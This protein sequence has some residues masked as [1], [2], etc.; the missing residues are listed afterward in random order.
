M[1]ASLLRVRR[2][3][4]DGAMIQTFADLCLYVFVPVDGL[5]RQVAAPHDRRP[6]PRSAF[7]DSEAI[8]VTLVAELLGLDTATGLLA[9]LDRHHRA[10]FPRLPERSRFNRR[11]R[12]LTEATNRI[13]AALMERVLG[14]LVP[15]EADP[16]VIDSLPG[17]VVGFAHARGP[18]RWY[19]E[20]SYGRVA[21]KRETIYGFKLHLLIAHGGLILDFVLA[22]AHHPDGA[23]TEQLLAD[24]AWAT[25]LGDKAHLN[26]PLQAWLAAHNDLILL[27]PK[28]RNQRQ[29]PPALL[30]KAINHFRQAIETVNSQL[31]FQFHVARTLAKC[32]SGLAARIQAKLTAHT[33]GIYLNCLLG[34]PLLALQAFAP[35]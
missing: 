35:I 26:A 24:K 18:H 3:A 27:T 22:P 19:G 13:R 20:A 28:R 21:S 29:P 16:G 31:A 4:G 1:L 12:Q 15:E 10:L 6:G 23:V 25:V 9:Y 5:Y 8:A 11:R 34:R 33:I 17:P 30:T 14:W 7:S 32:V 2:Y